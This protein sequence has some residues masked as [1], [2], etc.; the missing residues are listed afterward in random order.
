MN[1]DFIN[2]KTRRMFSYQD[3]GNKPDGI[4]RVTNALFTGLIAVILIVALLPVFV[5]QFANVEDNTAL[6]G[7]DYLD[8]FVSLGYLLPVLFIVGLFIVIVRFFSKSRE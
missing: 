2:M 8:T 6:A 4:E 1:A 5:S 3:D 7:W